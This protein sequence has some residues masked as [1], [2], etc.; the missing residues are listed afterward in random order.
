MKY[1]VWMHTKPAMCRTFYD[2][3]VDVVADSADDAIEEAIRRAAR[4][5]GHKEFVIKSVEIRK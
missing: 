1:R 4:I 2:G 3:K 5:H